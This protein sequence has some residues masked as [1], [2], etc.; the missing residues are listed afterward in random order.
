MQS[1]EYFWRENLMRVHSILF[2]TYMLA[3]I[4]ARSIETATIYYE[5]HGNVVKECR[6]L[7]A[8]TTF[9]ALAQFINLAILILTIFMSKKFSEELTNFGQCF[10]LVY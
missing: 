10:L 6:D 1:P 4:L 9:Y 5:N 2:M 8:D 7:M 3:Y